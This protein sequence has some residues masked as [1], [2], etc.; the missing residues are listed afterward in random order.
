VL[1]VF[2]DS[3]AFHREHVDVPEASL[4]EYDTLIDCLREDPEVLKRAHV[5]PARLCAAF[6][7]EH[8]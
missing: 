5:D 8:P 7:M 6:V 3:G 2:A 1:L 4:D